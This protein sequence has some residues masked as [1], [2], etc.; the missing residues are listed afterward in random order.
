[1]PDASQLPHLLKLLDDDSP[2]VRTK[3]QETLEAFGPEL[4]RELRRLDVRLT[5]RHEALLR[6]ILPAQWESEF[7]QAWLR[8]FAL[9]DDPSRIEA[10]FQLLAD[11]QL[12]EDYPMRLG[13]E[14]DRLA[15]EYERSELS[16]DALGLNRYLFSVRGFRGVT[17]DHYDPRNSN[18]VSVIERGTGIPISLVCLFILVGVRSG[19]EVE[20]CNFP[21]HFLARARV[22]GEEMLFDPFSGGRVLPPAELA[23]FLQVA[24]RGVETIFREPASA[25]VIMARVLRNLIVAYRHTGETE[26][27]TFFRRLLE[28]LQR[29]HRGSGSGREDLDSATQGGG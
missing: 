13:V 6:R 14:L 2:A 27:G 17:S 8:C 21:N 12:G 28:E 23:A 7:R 16:R 24:P 5:A 4:R 25:L 20:G 11:Y 18:L 26:H 15:A 10:A 29:F 22:A 3:V 19:I 9:K 1:M